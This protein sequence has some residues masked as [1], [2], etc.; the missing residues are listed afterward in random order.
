M[1]LSNCNLT[2]PEALRPEER[3]RQ[4]L[5][6]AMTA[7]LGYPLELLCVEK[8]LRELPHLALQQ[9]LPDRRIDVLCYHNFQKQMEPLL[10]IECKK[11][12][13]KTCHDD[14][15]HG[16]NYYVK[17]PLLALVSQ[18]EVLLSAVTNEG[19]IKPIHFLPSYKQLIMYFHYVRLHMGR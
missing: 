3:I 10:L 19:K 17:A 9:D 2:N 6:E 8:S 18:N 11:D 12:K 4:E 13:L 14:Q 16:Y 7:H 1:E 5:L 15:L